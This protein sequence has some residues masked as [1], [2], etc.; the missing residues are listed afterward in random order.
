MSLDKK[1]HIGL[2]ILLDFAFYAVGSLLFA[3][4]MQ[5]F[6]APN[7]IA[8][9]GVSAIAVVLNYLTGFPI[10]MWSLAL[11]VPILLLGLGFLGWRFT[12]KTLSAVVVMSVLTDALYFVVPAY[13]GDA[14]LSALFGGL[15][16][17]AG[18]AL[19]FMRDSTT[20]GVDIISRLIQMR[21]P[22]LPMGKL[23]LLIDVVIICL[24][25]LVFGKMEIVLYSLVAVAVS[26]YTIDSVMYGLDRGK[27]IYVFSAKTREIAK[28][29]I[30]E[31]ERG[32]TLLNATGGYSGENQQA[33]LVAVRLQQYHRLREI[34]HEEDSRA[35]IV[36]TDSSEVLGEGFKPIKKS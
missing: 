33:L 2:Q 18:M 11:N 30:D 15:L 31:L 6:I 24:S 21:L 12:L 23:L 7:Q 4:G 25:A 9:G 34:V 3:V 1:K 10:G 17:G 14:L 16:L 26:A 29:V 20:G 32:C 5:M 22:Y 27:L 28:R 19:I 8:P 36:V 35:F 13:Q